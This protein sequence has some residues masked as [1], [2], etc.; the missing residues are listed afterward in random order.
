[1]KPSKRP[2][3]ELLKTLNNTSMTLPATSP[4]LPTKDTFFDIEVNLEATPAEKAQRKPQNKGKSWGVKKSDLGSKGIES[5][6]I[7]SV[8]EEAAS[9]DYTMLSEQSSP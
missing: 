3:G 7:T 4:L 1:M 2:R 9:F 8:A 6:D 5:M